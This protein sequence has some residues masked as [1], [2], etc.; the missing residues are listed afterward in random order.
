[1]TKFS[2]E[3]LAEALYEEFPNLHNLA[4]E[5]ARQY[6]KADALSFYHLMGDEVQFFW[7]DIAKQIIEHAKEW[8]KNEGSCCVLS[9]KER[10]RLTK[11]QFYRKSLAEQRGGETA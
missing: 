6:G 5:M 11:L 9:E 4:E 10:T 7:K 8:E 3:T 1:M 2:V